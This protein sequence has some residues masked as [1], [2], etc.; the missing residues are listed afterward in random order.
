MKICL[1]FSPGGHCTE[2]QRI[3]QAFEEFDCFNVTIKNSATKGLQNTYFVH[4]SFSNH[5]CMILFHMCLI[6]IQ[7]LIILLKERPDVIISIGADVT[8]PLGILGKLMGKKII[9]IESIS[10]VV[11]LSFTGKLFYVFSDLFL[12]QWPHLKGKYE[13]STYWGNVL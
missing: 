3:K 6:T 4:D 1:A 8:I 9:F 13:K 10:R 5:V 7:S 12:V 11:D 2:L